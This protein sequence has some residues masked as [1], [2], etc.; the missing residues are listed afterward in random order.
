MPICKQMFQIFFY[1][2]LLELTFKE[3]LRDTS[4]GHIGESL[5]F[6]EYVYM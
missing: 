3:D 5:L 4:Y 6:W 1:V 2:Y